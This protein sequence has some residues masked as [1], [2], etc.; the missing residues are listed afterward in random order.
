MG[1]LLAQLQGLSAKP[2]VLTPAAEKR[3]KAIPM[4][5]LIQAILP[6]LSYKVGV[7][8]SEIGR[9]LDL[10]RAGVYHVLHELELQGIAHRGGAGRVTK[11]FLTKKGK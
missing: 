3:R 7:S 1:M 4:P 9:K 5:K 8:S 11:W 10:T 6:C 2:H